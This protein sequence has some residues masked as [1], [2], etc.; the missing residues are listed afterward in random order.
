MRF[1]PEREKMIIMVYS[2]GK[3]AIQKF[4]DLERYSSLDSHYRKLCFYW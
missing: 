2:L 1:L 3:P 4:L